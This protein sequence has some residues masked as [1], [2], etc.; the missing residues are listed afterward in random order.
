MRAGVGDEVMDR[1]RAAEFQGN[2]DSLG[3][4][5]AAHRPPPSSQQPASKK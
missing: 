3:A 2:G 4:G 5:R 1:A